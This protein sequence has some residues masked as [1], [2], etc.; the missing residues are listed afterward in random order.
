MGVIADT[1]LN[2]LKGLVKTLPQASL[3]S[4]ELALGVTKDEALGE[5]RD[6]ISIELEFRYAKEAVFLPY[7]PLF[8]TRPDGLNAVE[9][10]MWLL[11]NLWRALE[12]HETE[13]YTQAR[14]AMRGLRAEDPTPVVFFRLVTAAAEIL[15]KYPDDVLPKTPGKGDAEEVSEF[16]HY[17]DLHRIIR[18]TL[19]KLP[20][21]MGRIDAEKAATLR[22]MFKD[23]CA[24]SDEGGARLMEVIFANLDEGAQIIKF[25]ATV[26]DRP[27]DRF[28]AESELADF[29]ERILEHIEDG[30]VDLKAFM[31][32]KSHSAG[33][34]A[35]AGD[36]IAQ[37]LAQLASFAHYIELSRDGPW[38]KRSAEAHK[39][40]AVMV[41][42]QLKGAEKLFAEALPIRSERI[43][44]KTKREVPDFNRY[45][46]VAVIERVHDVAVF[47]REVRNTANAGGFAALHTKTVQSLEAS[48][49]IYFGTLLDIANGE[50][51]FD[52]EQLMTFFELVTDLMEALL[53]EEKA[54]VARRRIA[55][56]DIHRERSK[57]VA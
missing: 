37:C 54:V 49:D 29:G 10:P 24:I 30:L 6:L 34:L 13:L 17:L 18:T 15:R 8:E 21:Y 45:P 2:L 48:M 38:G 42:G 28:L 46:D 57:S 26:S 47:I 35:A 9:F 4:L 40:I 43:Y 32:N 22:L 51:P 56:S 11:D 23:A 19:A 20:D 39:K 52:S 14:Y 16:A 1:R 36:R 53:G 27:N 44:G 41:E 55:S 33:T 12:V 25:L 31:D 3:R 7:M 50:E 5:V